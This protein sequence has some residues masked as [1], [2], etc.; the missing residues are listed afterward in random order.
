MKHSVHE[1]AKSLATT[2]RTIGPIHSESAGDYLFSVR[3]VIGANDEFGG[4]LI[5]QRIAEP[6]LPAAE[7]KGFSFIVPA[8]ADVRAE[9]TMVFAETLEEVLQ[10]MRRQAAPEA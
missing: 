6:S 4:F 9:P 2:L 3:L 5:E 7:G 8:K 1:I 10:Y